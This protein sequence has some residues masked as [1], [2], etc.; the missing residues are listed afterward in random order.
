MSAYTY[1]VR[2][3]DNSLYTGIARDIRRRIQTHIGRDRVAAKY[4]KSH[5]VIS[6]EALWETVD[7][8][9]AARLEKRL[10]SLKKAE[11]EALIE[12][13]AEGLYNLF[14]MLSPED[15]RFLPDTTIEKLLE[16]GDNTLHFWDKK[17]AYAKL[18][19]YLSVLGKQESGFHDISSVMATVSLADTVS[20]S[21]TDAE[22]T[23]VTLTV[24]GGNLPMD[25]QNIAYRAAVLYLSL[26][27]RT[28]AIEIHIKKRIPIAAGLGGGSADAAAVLRLMQNAFS[29]L[30]EKEL[31]SAAATL[32]SDVPFCLLG[33]VAHCLGRGERMTPVALSREIPV[34]VLRST[35]TVS[36]PE[37]YRSLDL[38]YNDFKEKTD[39]ALPDGLLDAM[40]EGETEKVLPL[41]YN[42]FE[43]VILP[44]YP[45]A[46][47][48]HALLTE[49]G[50]ERVLMA[51]SGPTVVGFFK[52]KVKARAVAKT[53]GDSAV[54]AMV[55]SFLL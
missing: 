31:F 3:E 24:D 49:M 40:A 16:E 20:L 41:L 55:D 48:N 12:A 35:E 32:G 27:K 29:L 13:S 5:K 54:F 51:G 14:P 4:T 46:A 47:K 43:D 42:I 21:A 38:R 33:G 45:E 11:K 2:C 30:S 50:A 28:A 22:T 19:L 44:T 9:A 7:Y 18:N 37:A 1:I 23:S 15:Y 39:S 53:I 25:E 17:E 34:V 6:L 36:T 26:A 52:T 8:P 10:K